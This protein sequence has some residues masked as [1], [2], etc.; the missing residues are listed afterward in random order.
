MPLHVRKLTSR[1]GARIEGVDLAAVPDLATI[2]ALRASHYTPVL[3]V[4]A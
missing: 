4:A 2:P 3:E 1:I